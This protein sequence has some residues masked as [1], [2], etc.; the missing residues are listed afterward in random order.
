[1][2]FLT[3]SVGLHSTKSP[4]VGAPCCCVGDDPAD[5]SDGAG[6]GAGSGAGLSAAG[7]G[8]GAVAAAGAVDERLP[9]GEEVA[10]RQL[11]EVDLLDAQLAEERSVDLAV[12]AE[13][14]PCRINCLEAAAD[15]ARVGGRRR[16]LRL[17]SAL[18]RRLEL[19][20]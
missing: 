1:M 17:M 12:A 7:P 8:A 11:R 19:L 3:R 2:R 6:G 13:A 4:D 18:V 5:V 10:E 16:E 15:G 20:S 14:E 9:R